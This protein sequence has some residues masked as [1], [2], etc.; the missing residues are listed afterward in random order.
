MMTMAIIVVAVVVV[1]VAAAGVNGSRGVV[2]VVVFN[3]VAGKSVDS[4]FSAE[5]MGLCGF[6]M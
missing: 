3:K 4:V 6:Q 5:L 1:V 2:I